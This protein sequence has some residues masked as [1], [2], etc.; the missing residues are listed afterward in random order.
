MVPQTGQERAALVGRGLSGTQPTALA[1]A[2]VEKS[3]GGQRVALVGFTAAVEAGVAEPLGPRELSLSLTRRP[4]AGQTGLRGFS[5]NVLLA[6]IS[7]AAVLPGITLYGGGGGMA[8]LPVHVRANLGLYDWTDDTDYADGVQITG[9]DGERVYEATSTHTSTPATEPGVGVDWEDVWAEIGRTGSGFWGEGRFQYQFLKS[10]GAPLDQADRDWMRVTD[11]ISGAL[12]YTD[13]RYSSSPTAAFIFRS[14]GSFKVRVRYQNRD[15][16][17]SAWVESGTITVA[18]NTRAKR[19]V[20]GATGSDANNG[21]TTGTAKATING[22]LGLVN[23]DDFEVIVAD[24]TSC[25]CTAYTSIPG[26][27]HWIHR[28]GAGTEKPIVIMKQ[29]VGYPI[30]ALPDDSLCEGINFEYFAEVDPPTD[31]RR[32]AIE[33]VAFSVNTAIADCDYNEVSELAGAG[34]ATF[35]TAVL[36]L[37]LLQ[38]E[39]VMRYCCFMDGFTCLSIVGCVWNKGCNGEHVLR[40]VSQLAGSPPYD[41][42]RYLAAEYTNF[43][44]VAGSGKATYNTHMRH[45]GAYRCVFTNGSVGIGGD[46]VYLAESTQAK[47]NVIDGCVIQMAGPWPQAVNIEGWGQNVVRTCAFEN[48]GDTSNPVMYCRSYG[49]NRFLN[50]SVRQFNSATS[51]FYNLLGPT[52]DI[53]VR[54]C[55]QSI[56][57]SEHPQGAG[58]APAPTV[59]QLAGTQWQDNVLQDMSLNNPGKEFGLYIDEINYSLAQANAM[60][61]ADGNIFEDHTFDADWMPLGAGTAWLTKVR[62]SRGVFRSI[63]GVEWDA[64]GPAGCWRAP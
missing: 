9:V 3:L 6:Q 41:V 21:L 60:A 22:A 53:L 13:D 50:L 7:E 30:T 42:S 37:R 49:S 4:L 51:S 32:V 43:E 38:K 24:D 34:S 54:G 57:P 10:T 59:A 14:A 20:N 31:G 2:V 11:P 33:H 48:S 18:S 28:S 64:A 12:V 27:G 17:W 23:A 25:D 44:M 36:Y 61:W 45:T 47:N 63:N 1:E 35:P 62:S 15:K 8:P 52:D 40:A 26:T 5:R 29:A 55:M 19:Y 16:V 56:I 58:L 46:N 39:M